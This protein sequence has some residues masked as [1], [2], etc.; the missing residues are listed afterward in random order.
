M[1]V[2]A[3]DGW[4]V[5]EAE[6]GE[7]RAVSG[8]PEHHIG[9]AKV[10]YGGREG[11]GQAVFPCMSEAVAMA[12]TAINPDTGGYAYAVIVKPEPGEAVTHR[13]MVEW[14]TRG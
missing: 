8:L 1:E 6:D 4:L 9:A 14:F 7:R 10:L 11:P 5:A 12:R 3:V 13:S 2:T